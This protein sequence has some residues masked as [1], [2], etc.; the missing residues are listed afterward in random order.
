LVVPKTPQKKEVAN[1]EVEL[2]EVGKINVDRVVDC[3]GMV[4]PRPQLEVKRAASQMKEGEVAEVLITNPASVE[5]VPGI[6]KKA[7]C[8]LLGKVKEGNVFKLYFRKGT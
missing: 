4:C 1:M 8:T 2:P 5:A 6:L 7:G 3:Q